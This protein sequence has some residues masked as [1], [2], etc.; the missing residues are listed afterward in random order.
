MYCQLLLVVV[1]A[2]LRPTHGHPTNPAEDGRVAKRCGTTVAYT[3][4]YLL[5]ELSPDDIFD[6]SSDPLF[7]VAQAEGPINRTYTA[8]V[9]PPTPPGAENCQL[10]FDL[11]PVVPFET[12]TGANEV[13]V[14]QLIGLGSADEYR[15]SWNRFV[16]AEPPVTGLV[17]GNVTLVPGENKVVN[18]YTCSNTPDGNGLIFLFQLADA[19]EQLGLAAN[20]SFPLNAT[21]RVTN[22]GIDYG[23]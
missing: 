17:S 14:R 16:E 8:V 23:C 11:G 5:N 19:V 20:V 18:T 6:V 22:I 7:E 12:N 9:F 4:V 21:S 2:L 13:E 15:A 1:A 10:W 3:N